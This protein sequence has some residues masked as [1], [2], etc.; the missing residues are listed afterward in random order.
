MRNNES[1]INGFGRIEDGP[2]HII[3]D[4]HRNRK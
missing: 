4:R 3:D 2:R 1:R